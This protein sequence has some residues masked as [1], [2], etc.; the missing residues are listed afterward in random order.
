VDTHE[1]VHALRHDAVRYPL[2]GATFFE[3]GLAVLYQVSME[4]VDADRDVMAALR[5]VA[6]LRDYMGFEYYGLAGHFTHFLAGEHG[7]EA[8]VAFVDDQAGAR[9]I[10]DLDVLFTEHFGE[11]LQA[12]V[13]RYRS[14]YPSCSHFA[15]TRHAVEC[16]QPPVQPVDGAIDISYELACDDPH[17]LG[18]IDGW[19]WRSFTFD[20]TRADRYE[21][22]NIAMPFDFTMEI[23]DCD[24][25]CLGIDGSTPGIGSIYTNPELEPGRYLVRL[26]RPVDSPGR[27]GVHIDSFD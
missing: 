27:V 16:S 11:S 19:M 2:P 24:R 26:S 22:F 8:V 9:T 15:R 4:T 20:V 5:S 25:G 10:D 7:I 14:E 1:L 13:D 6:N 17:V 21:L 23:V 18:P 12:A 3:E